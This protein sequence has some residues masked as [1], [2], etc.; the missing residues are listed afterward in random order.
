M[1]PSPPRLVFFGTPD[2]AVPSLEALVRAGLPPV[3]VIS[4]PSRPAGR[5]YAAKDPPVAEAARRLGL[6]LVQTETVR[7]PAFLDRLRSEG[8]DLGIVVAFG[9]I[10]RQELLDLPR[11]GCFNLH[12]SLLPKYRGAAPIQAAV[13]NGEKVT[14][15][16]VQ[17]MVRALD[18]GPVVGAGDLPIGDDE[19]AA[20]LFPRLAALGAEVLVGAIVRLQHGKLH[21][22]PQDDSQVT[23]APRLERRQG[24]TD[25]TLPAPTLY[26]HWRAYTP[27]PGI[28][29]EL[30]GANLKILEC[31]P[32][33]GT[34]NQPTGTLLGLQDNAL[35]IACGGGTILAALRVQRPNR[36][37]IAAVDLWNGERLKGGE[38]FTLPAS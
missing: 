5:G 38:R 20:E 18:A 22:E 15:V 34:T 9:Q 29:T 28:F 19:T 11:H 2:F 27:W 6:D 14:G 31:R 12:A 16:S 30:N 17:Q 8:P 36:P 21:P 10:F 3:L 25:F 7:D 33:Q 1:T 37:A 26:N 4:Q 32:Q 23:F 35:A 13:A 24:A